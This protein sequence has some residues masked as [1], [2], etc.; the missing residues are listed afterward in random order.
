MKTLKQKIEVMQA[1]EDGQEIERK[2]R[3]TGEKWLEVGLPSWN[4][5][6]NDYRIKPKP[7]EF[8]VNVKDDGRVSLLKY[9]STEE[10]IQDC[11]WLEFKTIKVREVIE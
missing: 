6:D 1:F 5:S 8:W 4:W 2:I 10:A 11:R 9:G 3:P 7:L